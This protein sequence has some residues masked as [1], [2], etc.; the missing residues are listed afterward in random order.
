MNI[1]HMEC[2]IS[3]V[4]R[5][6]MYVTKEVHRLTCYTNSVEKTVVHVVNSR[7]MHFE[8]S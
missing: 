8:S 4:F 3:S 1:S 2:D 7:I 6:L 5:T